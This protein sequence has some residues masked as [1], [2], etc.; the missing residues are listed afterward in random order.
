MS[1]IDLT[2]PFS[3]GQ[4]TLGQYQ[5]YLK[6][7]EKW[8]K[9]DETYLKLKI[10]QIFCNMSAED[11]QR[12][13]LSEFEDTIQHIND[14][15]NEDTSKLINRFKMTGSDGQ[16]GERTVEFGFIP[17]LDD[18]SFG[19]YIDLETYVGKWESMHKAMAVLFRPITK[20]SKGYYLIE[21]Y[22]G[23][24]KYSE[25]MLDMPVSVAL[26]A[27]V[28]FYRLGIKLQNYTLDSLAKQML[29]EGAQQ[30][31]KLTLGKSGVGIN[32][33]IH[34]LR[35]MLDELTKLQKPV[36]ISAL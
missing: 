2:I 19:E 3:L 17:K 30:A 13:K 16:G 26:S 35:E 1:K 25:A 32:Q 34:L 15:F 20:D 22:Q 9:E 14:L 23:S 29:K 21:D 28:F 33:Y 18:I 4:I 10:L 27:T 24:A 12:I 36:F 11:V 8:D 6:I 31:S 5:D 7:L